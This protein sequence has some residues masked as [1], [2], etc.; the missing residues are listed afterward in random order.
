MKYYKL[1]STCDYGD[2]IR[3]D[4]RKCYEYE[5]GKEQWVRSGIMTFYNW[6]EDYRYN[7]YI[8]VDEEEALIQLSE[9]RIMFNKLLDLAIKVASDAH[10][11]QFDKGGNPYIL[12]PMAVANCVESTE[13]KIVAYLHDIIEDTNITSEDLENM[14]FTYR[15]V[16]SIKILTKPKNTSYEDYLKSVKM[17]SN[18]WH[19]KIADIK[20]N[21]DISRIPE[22]TAKDFAR[23]EK[24]KKAL[25][26]LES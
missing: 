23:I 6:P 14:G 22:P 2:I 11:N 15:I 10:S 4:G 12:H 9:Q 13:E 21:M 3:C 18:A 5:F 16:N 7:Q 26:F 19:V 8:L 24:Y 17:D 25:T 20:H 1:I